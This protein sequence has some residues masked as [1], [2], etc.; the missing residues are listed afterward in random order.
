MASYVSEVIVLVTERLISNPIFHILY[1]IT[2]RSFNETGNR[3]NH[4]SL[5]ADFGLHW[6]L[7]HHRRNDPNVCLIIT[8]DRNKR[9]TF[10]TLFTMT[11]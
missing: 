6:F 4:I 10:V 9:T 11:V 8:F 5:E 1:F 3:I 7:P 2:L